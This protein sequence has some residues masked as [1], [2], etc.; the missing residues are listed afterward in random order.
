MRAVPGVRCLNEVW[1]AK[2]CINSDE[3]A[4]Q[5]GSGFFK[6]LF[7]TDPLSILFSERSF[8][9]TKP[10]SQFS[11]RTC[12]WLP[13]TYITRDHTPPVAEGYEVG[14]VRQQVN[15]KLNSVRHLIAICLQPACCVFFRVNHCIKLGE[16][17]KLCCTRCGVC[18]L[19]GRCCVI[20]Y[21][22]RDKE[23]R[24]NGTVFRYRYPLKPS[25]HYMYRQFNIQQFYVL[26]TRSIYVFCVDLRTNSHYFPI[27]H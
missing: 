4:K 5:G 23:F 21:A 27:Q 25:G 22:P 14:T 15:A 7:R 24:C 19:H 16:H 20:L 10:C 3:R 1:C 9:L 11:Q 12:P 13:G 18:S 6:C 17:S 26:P 2:C 8:V